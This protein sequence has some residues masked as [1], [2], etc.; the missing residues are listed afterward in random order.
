MEFLRIHG[1]LAAVGKHVQ[2]V[3]TQG[4]VQ[5]LGPGASIHAEDRQIVQPQ[6]AAEIQ[7]LDEFLVG[8]FV[9]AVDCHG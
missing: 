5:F 1:F 4:I 7:H 2:H 6:L 8:G 9:G 3:A